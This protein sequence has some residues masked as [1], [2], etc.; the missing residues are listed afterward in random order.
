MV[1]TSKVTL[2]RHLQGKDSWDCEISKLKV[3]VL[4]IILAM[5]C[6]CFDCWFLGFQ[7]IFLW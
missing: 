3:A 6:S 2:I 1:L 4:V 5:I 7:D